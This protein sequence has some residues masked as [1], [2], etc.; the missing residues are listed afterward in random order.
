MVGRITNFVIVV[1]QKNNEFH[2]FFKKKGTKYTYRRFHSSF[3]CLEFLINLMCV[4]GKGMED[5][6]FKALSC[7]YNPRHLKFL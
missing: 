6:F 5:L 7:F 3:L 1:K 2:Y 4:G